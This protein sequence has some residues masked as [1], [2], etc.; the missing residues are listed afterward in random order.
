MSSFRLVAAVLVLSSV[1]CGRNDTH[2]ARE[3]TPTTTTPTTT[4]TEDRVGSTAA[5]GSANTGGNNGTTGTTGTTTAQATASA[6]AGSNSG[7]EALNDQQVA[8]ITEAANEG[9]IAQAKVAQGKARNP[10]VKAFAAKM[11]THHGQAKDKQSKLGLS[12][13]ESALSKTLKDEATATLKSL[14]AAPAGADFD[15]TYIQTQVQGHQK[16]LDTINDRL[17]PS[18]KDE[19]LAAYVKEIKPTVEAHLKEARE[20]EQSLPAATS[21]TT[22]GA[23]GTGATTRGAVGM[24]ATTHGAVGA[25]ATTHGAVGAGATTR[26]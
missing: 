24:G 15:R 11:I 8:A 3:T 10:R 22:S 5:V 6:T 25:G 20:I 23:G 1:G 26:P 17:L 14:N 2:P 21:A 18:V 7:S 16:V 4:G 19:K 13:A 12:T 9:E